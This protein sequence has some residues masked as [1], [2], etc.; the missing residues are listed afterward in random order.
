LR[1]GLVIALP[2]GLGI[3]LPI[4]LTVALSIGL[5]VALPIRLAIAWPGGRAVSL[6]VAA[7][8]LSGDDEG[9]ALCWNATVG[10]DGECI[11]SRLVNETCGDRNYAAQS[12]QRQDSCWFCRRARPL[13]ALHSPLLRSPGVQLVSIC[14]KVS[15]KFK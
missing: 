6:A 13:T 15:D 14:T 8:G 3:V 5:A 10:L 2:V 7:A 12:E 4:S 9:I 1:I 11:G